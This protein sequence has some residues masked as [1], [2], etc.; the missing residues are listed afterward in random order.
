MNTEDILIRL[1]LIPLNNGQVAAYT[2]AAIPEHL[3]IK[4]LKSPDEFIKKNPSTKEIT[5]PIFFVKAGNNNV[6]NSEGL[7]SNEIFGLTME[8][9]SGIWG[10]IDL[11]NYFI[12][13]LIY[14]KLVRMD[15]KFRDIAHGTKSFTISP[16]GELI[17]DENGKTGLKWLKSNMKNIK[18]KQTNSDKRDDL[19]KFI[20][21]NIDTMWMNKLLVLPAYYRDVNTERGGKVSVGEINNLY[22]S[23]LISVK[24]IKETED[25]GIPVSDSINGR[26]QELIM[27]VYDWFSGNTN[28]A[29]EGATGLSKKLG[30]IRRAGMSKT[31]DYGSRLILSAPEL[32]VETVDDMLDIKHASVPLASICANFEPYMVYHIKK[33]FENEFGMGTIDVLTKSGQIVQKRVKDPSIYYSDERIK[34]ELKRF[35]HGYSNRLIPIEIPI[36]GEKNIHYMMFKGKSKD[37]LDNAEDIIDG[38]EVG[39]SP[40][41][42]SRRLTWCDIFFI[43]AVECTKDKHVLITRYPIDSMYNQFPCKIIVSSTLETEP[44]FIGNDFYKYYPK[45]TE[46]M[47]GSD[48]SN[49]FID[50]LRIS[51]LHLKRIVGD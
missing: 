48:T 36:E 42:M 21:A 17:E 27:A 26:I 41:V 45:I 44:L 38:K 24:G 29:L 46:D 23:I 37:K 30:L 4:L 6:P 1:N 7:L 11:H 10:Y 2:E 12:H 19:I 34:E 9:R 20:N 39:N 40:L 35:I 15:R 25:Y 49:M 16:S 5:S 13:P 14:K 8:E 3:K 18:I 28:D 47:I 22:S 32:K 50:T 51:N 33:F 31:T 43:A